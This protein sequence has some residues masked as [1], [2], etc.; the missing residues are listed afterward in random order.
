MCGG[1][2]DQRAS[3]GTAVAQCVAAV[4]HCWL[5]KW[6]AQEPRTCRC[7]PEICWTFSLMNLSICRR[8]R[9]CASAARKPFTASCC[10]QLT[11][12]G[13]AARCSSTATY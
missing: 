1:M 6:L 7:V 13:A 5:G 12:L 2:A 8:S 10:R 9:F 4:H 11:R 3:A